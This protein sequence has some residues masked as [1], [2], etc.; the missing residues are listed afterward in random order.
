MSIKGSRRRHGSEGVIRWYQRFIFLAASRLAFAASPKLTFLI[1][2]IF[3]C[4]TKLWSINLSVCAPNFILRNQIRSSNTKFSKTKFY[5]VHILYIKFG[6]KKFYRSWDIKF[7][8]CK[9]GSVLSAVT[10]HTKM[11]I[12]QLQ[13]L[14]PSTASPT[15]P[16]YKVKKIIYFPR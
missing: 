1:F 9:F 11:Q 5:T 10:A 3:V 8:H 4:R 7:G 15:K 16:G 13:I 14:V 12:I 2:L 6:K